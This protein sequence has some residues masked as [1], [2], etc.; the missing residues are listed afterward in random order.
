MLYTKFC[1]QQSYKLN[2][3]SIPKLHTYSDV[4][5]KIYKYFTNMNAF[6]FRIFLKVITE[7]HILHKLFHIF[8]IDVVTETGVE[9]GWN[10]EGGG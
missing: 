3:Y 5:K 6:Y 2:K 8:G 4:I 1:R 7:F 9:E 10:G